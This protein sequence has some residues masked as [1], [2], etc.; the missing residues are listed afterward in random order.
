[1][2]VAQWWGGMNILRKME[3]FDQGKLTKCLVSQYYFYFISQIPLGI[4]LAASILVGNALGAGQSGRACAI[5]KRCI[6][7]G[8][9]FK[10]TLQN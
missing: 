9:K 7:V 10:D 4:S 2:V 1:M 3:Y 8:C 6:L 5:T